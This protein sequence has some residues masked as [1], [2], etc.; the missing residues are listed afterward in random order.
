MKTHQHEWVAEGGRTCP[1]YEFAN[2]SQTVYVCKSCGTHDY[3]YKGGPAHTECF[4]ECKQD[5]KEEI[6]EMWF[7]EYL[8]LSH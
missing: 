5:F 4:S 7:Q 8:Y 3:G 6:A 1:K 2:C